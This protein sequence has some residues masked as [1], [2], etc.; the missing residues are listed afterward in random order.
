MAERPF[1]DLAATLSSELQRFLKPQVNGDQPGER[2]AQRAEPIIQLLMSAA[3]RAQDSAARK[4]EDSARRSD[5]D[6]ARREID[7]LSARVD[8]LTEQNRGLERQ[9]ARLEGYVEGLRAQIAAG[10]G[11]KD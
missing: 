4:A 1:D 5:T 2:P 3:A 8:A 11:R 9:I 7:H 10:G 6:C